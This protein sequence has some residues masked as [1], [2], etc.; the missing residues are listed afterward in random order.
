MTEL[1]FRLYTVSLV[2]IMERI[3]LHTTSFQQ[4]KFLHLRR[5]SAQYRLSLL[6]QGRLPIPDI[7]YYLK[8]FLIY[9]EE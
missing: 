5:L 6:H 8:T 9:N 1:Q 4:S 2:N 3:Y 7:I